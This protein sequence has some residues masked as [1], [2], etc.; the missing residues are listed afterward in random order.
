MVFWDSR[1]RRRASTCPLFSNA[2]RRLVNI[3]GEQTFV[4]PNVDPGGQPKYRVGEIAEEIYDLRSKIARGS[5]IP[6]KFLE[7]VRLRNVLDEV[8]DP[9][10]RRRN[11]S[12][13]CVNVLYFC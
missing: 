12:T 11:I 1:R 8:I 4:L 3:L 7:Q 10:L 9:M 2:G 13:L 5:L 6:K